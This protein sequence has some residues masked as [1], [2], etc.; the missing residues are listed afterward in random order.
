MIPAAQF[1]A[2]FASDRS[3]MI[4]IDNSK[5]VISNNSGSNIEAGNT[6]RS[7]LA[8]AAV[9]TNSSANCSVF[10]CSAVKTASS[11]EAQ[12][13]E[14][15]T[16]ATT[17]MEPNV[18]YLAPP[19]LWPCIQGDASA[20]CMNLEEYIHMPNNINEINSKDDESDVFGVVYSMS[21]FIERFTI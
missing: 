15:T 9:D 7:D 8:T 10:K 13:N 16:V 19:P 11:I 4:D 17:K 14:D 6:R 18:V 21:A 20:S 12:L 2:H 3:H 1:V 5:N